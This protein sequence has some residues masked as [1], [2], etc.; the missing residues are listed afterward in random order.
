[1]VNVR[2]SPPGKVPAVNVTVSTGGV[3][4]MAAV[5]APPGA[6]AV[7]VRM[8]GE[9]TA[10][11]APLRVMTTLPVEGM[12]DAGVRDTVMIT[13]VAPLT[14]LLRVIAGWFAPSVAA[15]VSMHNDIS[16]K[17]TQNIEDN[18]FHGWLIIFALLLYPAFVNSFCL[19]APHRH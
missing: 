14:A 18:A 12:A 10:S 16:N 13:P 11:P 5:P 17:S 7:K 4:A 2:T 1:M 19:S 6:P 8:P 3:P 9:A 15:E